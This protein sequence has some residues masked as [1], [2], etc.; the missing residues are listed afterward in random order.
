MKHLFLIILACFYSNLLLASI[1]LV[2]NSRVATTLSGVSI[3]PDSTFEKQSNGSLQ[4]GELLEVLGETNLEHEDD[5]QNQKFK[6]FKIRSMKGK[7]GWVYGD[8]IAVSISKSRIDDKLQKVHKQKYS[9]NNGFEK[10]ILWIGGIEGR[11]N[12]HKQDLLN[13]PYKEYYIVI[14]ND[15]GDCMFINSGSE[16]ARG[17]MDLRYFQ[18]TDT[19]GDD[20]PEIL[21]QTSSFSTEHD[22]ENRILEIYSFQ[23]GGLNRIFEERMSLSYGANQHTPALF[24]NIE[25]DGEIVRVAYID[26]LSCEN[27]HLDND[28]GSFNKKRDKCMEYV[29]YTYAWSDRLKQY[30]MIYKESRTAPAVGSRKNNLAILNEP[31][32]MGKSVGTV[33]RSDRMEII[34]QFNRPLLE[35]GVKKTVPY[36]FVKLKNGNTGFVKAAE[37]GFIDIEHAELLNQ[38]YRSPK[39]DLKN[40]KTKKHFLKITGD[41]RSSYTGV[42]GR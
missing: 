33:S 6:W 17:Q 36:F 23:T 10:A 24:K 42:R 35:N 21:L 29:T 27:Y 37:V 13:P 4:V 22:V 14:S 3:Y 19:T 8:G 25:V 2:L 32:I 20:I 41:N 12:F 39:P 34:K 28:Y 9:F 40:W 15:R 30:R 31:S 18:F 26:Y 38:Y 16:N 11:D 5:S 1:D 7:E